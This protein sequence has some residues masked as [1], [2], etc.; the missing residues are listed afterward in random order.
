MFVLMEPRVARIVESMHWAKYRR[1]PK[2][3]LRR[4]FLGAESGGEES[5]GVVNCGWLKPYWMAV[6]T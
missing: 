4:I 6:Q 1:G 2:I 3:S 5:I